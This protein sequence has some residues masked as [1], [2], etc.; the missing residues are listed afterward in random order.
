M[1]P[2]DKG[3]HK[4][5]SKEWQIIS[6]K[7]D[8]KWHYGVNG[9]I[10]VK[11]RKA[12]SSFFML[13]CGLQVPF[14]F[15]TIAIVSG[16]AQPVAEDDWGAIGVLW[17]FLVFAMLFLIYILK[18]MITSRLVLKDNYMELQAGKHFYQIKYSDIKKM[19]FVW[20]QASWETQYES[21]GQ[22]NDKIRVGRGWNT[23]YDVIGQDDQLICSIDVGELF[24]KTDFE[25]KMLYK[26]IRVKG[27]KG[28]YQLK[29][30][31]L[32][33]EQI[34]RLKE[35]QVEEVDVS[36]ISKYID[37]YN[38]KVARKNYG[39][40][41]FTKSKRPIMEMSDTYEAGFVYWTTRVQ[42]AVVYFR[43]G[44]I[45]RDDIAQYVEVNMPEKDATVYYIK[46]VDKDVIMIVKKD[47]DYE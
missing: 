6:F 31:T 15:T 34:E 19:V 1:F 4:S 18:I 12:D 37:F 9:E 11:K 2:Y 43:D 42:D 20:R 35:N 33:G 32:K 41:F 22:E 25:D 28:Y 36:T 16:Q 29:R 39:L 5:W 44:E 14:L 7:K 27:K 47:C 10:R 17:M 26:G 46:N 38:Q 24:R 30:D 40:G 13:L 45:T 23:F 3:P 21:V 8:C